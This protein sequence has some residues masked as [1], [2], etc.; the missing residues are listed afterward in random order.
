MSTRSFYHA[1]HGVR[2]GQELWM[3]FLG[4]RRP[5]GLQRWLVTSF[6]SGSWTGTG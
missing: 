5:S 1:G 6:R 2:Y 4:A 3:R